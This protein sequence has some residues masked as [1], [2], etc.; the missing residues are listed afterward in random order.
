MITRLTQKIIQQ[1][2][3]PEVYLAAEKMIAR[4][5]VIKADFAY[6]EVSGRLKTDYGS[7]SASFRISEGERFVQTQCSCPDGRSGIMCVHAAALA[8]SVMK[9]QADPELQQKYEA[10]QEHAR[11]MEAVD[12]SRCIR[13]SD[14]GHPARLRLD[15]ASVNP[16]D[17][18]FALR[19]ECSGKIFRPE[20]VAFPVKL[21]PKEESLLANIEEICEGPARAEFT[22]SGA[23][24]FSILNIAPDDVLTGAVRSAQPLRTELFLDLL[25]GS[26]DLVITLESGLRNP[27]YFLLSRQGVAWSEGIFHRLEKLLPLPYRTLYVQ[28]VVIPRAEMMSFFAKEFPLLRAEMP[29]RNLSLSPES[30]EA[31]P[32]VPVFH[33]EVCGSEVSLAVTVVAEYGDG[34]GFT[35]RFAAGDAGG[36]FSVPDPDDPYRFLIRSFAAEAAA[37]RL[38]APYGLT[39]TQGDKLEPIVG[40]RNVLNF[41]GSAVPEMRRNNWKITVEGPIR[42]VYDQI[43]QVVPVVKIQS[44]PDG[45]F[46]V[47]YTFDAGRNV[48]VEP[49]EIQRAIQKGDSYIMRDGETYLL[50]SRAVTQMRDVFS[51]CPSRTSSVSGHFQLP[52][53]YAPF[54]QSS[55]QALEGIDVDQPP[56]WRERAAQQNRNE[57]LVPVALDALEDTLR[58][59]QKEGVYWLRFLENG[60]FGGLLADEMGLGK[61]LQTLAW[62][63][64]QRVNREASGLPALIVCPT[65]LVENWNREAEKFVPRLKRLVVSGTKRHEVFSEIGQSDLVITSYALLRRDIE[66]YVGQMFSVAV[67]DEAQHIKNRTT[68][69]ALAAKQIRSINKLV[70]SGTPVEN[71]VAD[72]WSIMDFLMPGYLGDYDRFRLTYEQPIGEGGQ[73]GADAQNKLRRKLNPFLLRRLKKDVAKDLP[74]KIR[75]VS[76]CRLSPDQERVYNTL[77]AQSK[78]NIGDLVK[79]KGFNAARLQILAILMK[80]RQVCCHLALLK[81]YKLQPEEKPSAKMEQ[82]FEI[83]DEA[84]DGGSRV[85]VFSQFTS[86]LALIREALEERGLRYS[87]LDGSTTN[88]FG[89]CEEFNQNKDIPVFLISLKAGGTGLNLTGADT[90]VHFDPWWN[91]AVE[92][93]A[94]DRAHRIGQKKKVYAIKLI[95]EHTVEERVLAMQERKQQVIDATIGTTDSQVM[96]KLS[97]N[98]VRE[99]MG[100]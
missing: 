32:A 50:D 30:F 29:I 63:S 58:P 53:V 15:V 39:G 56:D 87:Y 75:K 95:A 89:A 14:R 2:C 18:L 61:T 90:V 3:S 6:P 27:I 86:M 28:P 36:N 46:D 64:L 82:F 26:S 73:L 78:K 54:V 62:I 31:V 20:E 71:S 33:A 10:E 84:M 96:E 67:L 9:R 8:I 97:W 72:L 16:T 4:G 70:L 76:Y 92:D 23:D 22:A 19:L 11:R 7:R 79:E 85:L 41:L 83:L 13:R 98:D 12:L 80:L 34:K 65:S 5:E 37:V 51:D 66:M 100:L 77:L 68:Q 52:P 49:A 91:P 69:N 60:G 47:S 88:R 93:Q 81:N 44:A 74:D 24:L 42:K 1:W 94:T 59:Y 99:I 43:R 38:P 40:V 25:D 17:V 35:K 45:W 57:R 48:T 21:S 55:I